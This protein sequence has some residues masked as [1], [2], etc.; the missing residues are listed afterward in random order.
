[1]LV[2]MCLSVR[3]RYPQNSIIHLYSEASYLVAVPLAT[4][5]ATATNLKIQL[6][7]QMGVAI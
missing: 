3:H 4:A 7:G 2:C 1:M 5:T 6:W